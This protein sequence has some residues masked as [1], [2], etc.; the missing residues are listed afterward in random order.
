MTLLIVG[1]AVVLMTA[2]AV[3]VDATAAYLQ[4]Q[5]LMTLADGAALAGAD[6]GSRNEPDLYSDGV[7]DDPR[8]DLQQRVAAAAVADHL[9]ATGAHADYPG[10]SWTVVLDRRRRQRR[11]TRP[12]AA[13]PASRLPR[14]AR[15]RT[16]ERDGVRD[17]AAGLG[18][19]GESSV[20]KRHSEVA[21]LR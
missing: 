10:L 18:S 8:L 12:G 20:R 11:R 9:A 4:R 17:R 16:G 6:A 14:G 19:W 1:L 2:I 13:R 3:V 5:G 21:H 7:A 15:Q